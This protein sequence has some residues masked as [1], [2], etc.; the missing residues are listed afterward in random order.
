MYFLTAKVIARAI[1]LWNMALAPLK[2]G[3][4]RY[5]RFEYS[6]P[7]YHPDPDQDDDED[8]DDYSERVKSMR[9]AAKPEPGNFR[10][11]RYHST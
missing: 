9:R 4:W 3:H 5:R 6:G 8:D 7:E 11:P 10:P 1:P 2:V